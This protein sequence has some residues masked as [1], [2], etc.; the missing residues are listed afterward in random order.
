MVN[1]QNEMVQYFQTEA[2][3]G[4]SGMN[5]LQYQISGNYQKATIWDTQKASQG[6]G[7]IHNYITMTLWRL[8]K[9]K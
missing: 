7:H 2:G 4:C 8:I 1:V 3:K 6:L 9:V 5:G